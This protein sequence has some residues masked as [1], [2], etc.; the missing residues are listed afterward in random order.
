[1]LKHTVLIF[2]FP[3]AIGEG[4]ISAKNYPYWTELL[5]LLQKECNLIQLGVVGEKQ[6]INDFRLNL[7]L[8]ELKK[9]ITEC[10][11]WISCDSFAPH[12][13]KHIG[14]TGAVI[15]GK[16]DPVIFGYPE[17]L[18]ILKDRKHLRRD[19]FKYWLEEPFDPEVFLPPADVYKLIKQRFLI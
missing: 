9:L 18:N 10:S 15:W 19:Q 4:K 7:P 1:M 6:L 14:K 5:S 8:E 2:P 11:F 13:A 16:S 3:K 12:L 17:N